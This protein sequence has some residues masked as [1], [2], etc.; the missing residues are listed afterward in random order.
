[1]SALLSRMLKWVIIRRVSKW[2]VIKT[3]TKRRGG[4]PHLKNN[5]LDQKGVLPM[6]VGF[7]LKL[8]VYYLSL[9]SCKLVGGLVCGRIFVL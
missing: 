5:P 2:V 4:R 8:S 7:D 9:S 3:N 1:M 6:C